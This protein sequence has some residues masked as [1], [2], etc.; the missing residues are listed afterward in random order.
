LPPGVAAG[1]AYTPVGGEVLYVEAVLLPKGKDVKLTGKLG[2][3]MRE[4]AEAAQSIIQSWSD[5]LGI[6]RDVAVR[7]VHIHV[8]AGATPKDGPS[9]GVT[10]ATALA[11][12]Y[13]GKPARSDTAMTGEITLSG[14]VLPVGG[15]KEKLLAAHRA[16][17][18]RIILPA[19]N[20]PDLED[21]PDHVRE[22]MDFTFAE[23]I[24]DVLTAAIP[25]LALA[26][27]LVG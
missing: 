5:R 2:D 13:T 4:S 19:Q 20:E 22:E 18:N 15:I 1:L 23:R 26:G 14:L 17:I 8:P 16:Q 3:V 7:G 12:A 9:A 25:E 10:M 6:E 21:L 24:E 27:E 11:S